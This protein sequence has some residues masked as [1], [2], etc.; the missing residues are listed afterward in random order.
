MTT[1]SDMLENL[2]LFFSFA[3][4]NP[5][6]WTLTLLYGLTGSDGGIDA[7]SRYPESKNAPSRDGF[8]L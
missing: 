2:L 7:G 8:T 6:P 5:L 4:L 3:T 1:L